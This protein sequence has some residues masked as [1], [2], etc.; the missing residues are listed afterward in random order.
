VLGAA[1]QRHSRQGDGGQRDPY[2]GGLGVMT[3]GQVAD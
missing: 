1:Q 3:G 2:G